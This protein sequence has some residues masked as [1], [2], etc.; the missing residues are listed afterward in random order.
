M[1]PWAAWVS[2][3]VRGPAPPTVLATVTRSWAT[4]HA[5]ART[6]AVRLSTSS[7]RSRTRGPTCCRSRRGG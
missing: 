7:L 1:Q 4:T 5:S 3:R 6:A 2:G